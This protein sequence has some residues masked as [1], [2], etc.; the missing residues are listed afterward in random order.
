MKSISLPDAI[1]QILDAMQETLTAAKFSGILS[2]VNTIVLGDRARPH[3]ELPSLWVFAAPAL[4]EHTSHGL[5][6]TWSMPVNLVALRNDEVPE[7]GFRATADLAARANKIIV[8]QRDLGLG[9]VVDVTSTRFEP[10]REQ[11]LDHL[12]IYA[13]AATVTVKFNVFDR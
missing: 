9:F 12:V 8:S 6:E 7:Q 10:T 4:N 11:T 3:P 13:A 2:D 1:D 5:A